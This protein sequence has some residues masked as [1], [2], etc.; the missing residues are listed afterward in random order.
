[1]AFIASCYRKVQPGQ[2]LV[3]NKPKG[4]EVCF[5]GAIVLPLIH[6]AETVDLHAKP[7]KVACNALP[8][9][10]GVAVDVHATFLMRVNPSSEDVLH[11]VK[12]VGGAHAMAPET[13]QQLFEAKFSEAIRVA[14][15]AHDFATI[16]RSRHRLRDAVL[17]AIGDDLSGYALQDLTLTH[18]ERSAH[19]A[20]SPP[21]FSIPALSPTV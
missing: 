19:E 7:L 11:V 1:M 6:S 12:L 10:D 17:D 8:S 21:S 13:L 15:S 9:E 3:V 5:T 14:V 4:A 2:V 18:V 16:E 20:Q